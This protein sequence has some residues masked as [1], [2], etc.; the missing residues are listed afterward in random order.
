MKRLFFFLLLIPAVLFAQTDQ[1]YLTGAVPEVDGKVVFSK[2]IQAPSLSQEQLF[3]ILSDWAN[4][5]YNGEK[6]R[7]VYQKPDEGAIASVGSEYLVF[8]SSALSLDR[9]LINYLLRIVCQDQSCEIQIGSIR[10]E[11][12]VSYQKEPEKYIAEEWITDKASLK[13]NKL[14]RGP[15]KFRKETI[16]LVDKL[17]NEITNKINERVSASALMQHVPAAPSAPVVIPVAPAV[18]VVPVTEIEQSV[19][20]EYTNSTGSTLP[21]Y[22]TIAPDKIPGNI[23]KMIQND[24]MMITAG[25]EQ[26]TDLAT[27]SWGGLGYAFNKPVTF[28]ITDSQSNIFGV[29]KSSSTY[30]LS[31]YTEAY[32]DVLDRNKE[33]HTKDTNRVKNSGLTLL[34]TPEGSKAFLEAW[35]IIEC[36]KISS[37]QATPPS[38]GKPLSGNNMLIGEI[39]NVWIK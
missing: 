14:L 18:P 4:N 33:N 1:R 25:N 32:R 23:I 17:F 38:Q 28:C 12:N 6:N 37:L 31:F 15:G 10:Y 36:R 5:Y 26:E 27:I 30:T 22:K 2:K 9:T 34:S 19:S 3:G 7:V 13:K 20:T 21:G 11:Y 24:L 35:M 8:N 16:D 39:L 29:L